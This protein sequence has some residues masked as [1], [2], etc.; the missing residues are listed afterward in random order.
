[1][2]ELPEV[3]ITC[4]GITP[5]VVGRTVEAVAVRQPR[6][7]WPVPPTLAHELPGQTIESVARRGKYLLLGTAIGNVIL[8]LGMSGSLRVVGR[9]FP[10]G[11]YDHVDLV[12]SGGDCLRLRDPR[13]FGAVLW[14]KRDVT[15]HRLLAGLGPDP[16]DPTFND[17]YLY[18]QSRGRRRA[19]RDFLIDGHVVAGLG[20]IYA[21]EALFEAGI[22]PRRAAGRIRRSRYRRL[23]RAVRTT[24]KRAL[25]AG[26]T[27]LRDFRGTSG[28]PGYFQLQTRVYRHDG[29]PCYRCGRSRVRAAALGGRRVFFCPRCQ[30]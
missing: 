4:R 5:H 2:P 13:R 23:V 17:E 12:L 22:D 9:A 6:L 8:H 26:G 27:T 21:N 24:I 28:E 11:K 30:L 15:E 1:M 29:E 7:R 20:N 14:T 10:P 3:E 25:E 16:L 19:I 18:R